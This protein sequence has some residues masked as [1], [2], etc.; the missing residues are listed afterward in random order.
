M[1]RTKPLCYSLNLNAMSRGVVRR[2]W[3]CYFPPHR[4]QHGSK[5]GLWCMYSNVLHLL[6][7]PIERNECNQTVLCHRYTAT[8]ATRLCRVQQ[9]NCIMQRL[10]QPI[11]R[12]KC[13]R[14]V[15]CH[16][17]SATSATRLQHIMQH[18]SVEC[19]NTTV[20]CN[21]YN[22]RYN[23]TSATGLHYATDVQL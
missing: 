11:Y 10:Q 23:A 7:Q 16:R 20:S 5:N 12:N 1:L 17:Y 4:E 21:G 14:T 22:S 18:D 2:I 9:H 13:N 3:A 19:N 8:S 15:L 6:Q